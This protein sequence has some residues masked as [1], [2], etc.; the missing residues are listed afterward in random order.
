MAHRLAS[1]HY[2]HKKILIRRRGTVHWEIEWRTMGKLFF[3]LKEAVAHIESELKKSAY[4]KGYDHD[5]E[6]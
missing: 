3:S 6:N 1:G 2:R 5:N 4:I